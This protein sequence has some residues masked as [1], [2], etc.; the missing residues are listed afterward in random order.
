MIATDPT[1]IKISSVKAVLENTHLGN[2]ER[3]LDKSNNALG[4][5]LL[6]NSEAFREYI[7][8]L[9]ELYNKN[10]YL[11][12]KNRE[13][14]SEKL[15]A[16]LLDYIIQSK[17]NM[18]V[19]ELTKGE[20]SAASLLIKAKSKYLKLAQLEE[21][22]SSY[23]QVFE[24]QIL[25]DLEIIP[26][27]RKGAPETIR[28]STK[29]ES[30]AE[31]NMYTD[32]MRGLRDD[33]NTSELYDA[34]LRIAIVQG[35]YRTSV[36]IKNIIPIEDYARVVTDLVKGIT[37][38]ESFNA[39]KDNLLFQ[40]NNFKDST[41]V[42]RIDLYA[43]IDEYSLRFNSSTGEESY[44]Y[45]LPSIINSQLGRSVIK[46]SKR[47]KGAGAELIVVPRI[48]ESNGDS[49]DFQT[50]QVI[51]P[52]QFAEAA[53][54]DDNPFTYVYGYQLV[55]INGKPLMGV[56][57]KGKPTNEYIYKLVNLYGDGKFT[58]EYPTNGSKSLLENGT[59]K[60]ST[61]F[62]NEEVYAM[63][64]G[65][66]EELPNVQSQSTQP[67]P[68]DPKGLDPF[69]P[70][71]NV[72]PKGEKV[73]EGIYV[74]QEALTKDKQL[75]LFEYLKPF[76]EAQGK[77]TNVSPNA[78]IMIGLGL[79]WDYKKNNSEK[80]S[81]NVGKN[82]AGY[83]TAYAY[84]DLS[85][86]GKPLGKIT[87]RFV[88]LMNKTTGVDISNYDGAIVNIYTN[89][90]FIS[91]HS[92]LE[93]SETAEKY[94]VVVANIGGS[95]NIILGTDANKISKDLKSGAGYLFGYE[96]K[97]RKIPHSTY[98]SDVKGFLPSITVSQEGKTFSEG[99]YRVSITMR[100]VMPLEPG[101]PTS[102]LIKSS[103]QVQSNEVKK[104]VEISSNA[105][106]LAAALTNPTELAKSKGNL[107]ES[108]PVNFN[109]KTYRDAE[110]AYQ[111]LKSTA[112]K[113]E[114]P[115][116][117]YNLMVKI[118]KA[119]LEQ[120]PRLV[121]EIT[122][123]GGSAWI[124]SSTHQPTKQNSVWETGGKNWFIKSLNDA[125]LSI[126]Q[127]NEDNETEQLDNIVA[128]GGKN[129]IV[130][131]S[132]E[133]GNATV[134]FTK[135]DGTKGAE[136]TS[137]KPLFRKVSVATYAQDNPDNVVELTDL[138][139]S[140]KYL[141]IDS[142]KKVVSLNPTSYGDEIVSE[143]VINRVNTLMN[144]FK[145]GININ[146]GGSSKDTT[147]SPKFS[148][149]GKTINTAFDLTKG[150]VTALETLSDFVKNKNGD[151]FITLQGPAGTGKT[152]VIGYLQNYLGSAYTFH[153]MAPT[154]AATA[155]LAFATVKT[156]NKT[157]PA[158]VASSFSKK[159]NGLTK[160][161]IRKLA[162]RNNV[163]VIDEVSMLNSE[164]FN[165]VKNSIDG[166]VIKVIFMGDELQIPEVTDETVTEKQVNKAFS[167]F[168]Q[169]KLTEVKRTSDDNI[170][171][172][173]NT[174]R[175]NIN[176]KIPKIPN[177]NVLKYLKNTQFN[178]KLA[179]S[180][181]TNPEDTMVIAFT[182][183]TVKEHNERI[184]KELGRVG[185][186]QKDDVI[187]GYLGYSSKQI[188]NSDIAN[189][190]QYTVK[191]VKK[192]GSM[193][194]I[195]ATSKKL[196]N[197]R[198]LGVE[199]ISEEFTTGYY[200]LSPN[201]TFVFDDI[202]IVDMEANNAKVSTLM[203]SV[204][205]AKV[206]AQKNFK[207]WYKFYDIVSDVSR[208]MSR[209]DLGDNYIYN[210]ITNRME[211]YEKD[212]HKALKKEYA[213]IYVEK[214]IGL[215]HAVTVH[216]SQGATFK[217]VFFDANSLP[218]GAVSILYNGDRVVGMEKHSLIYVGMSRAS[219]TLTVSDDN[220]ENFYN[221]DGSPLEQEPFDLANTSDTNSIESTENYM[222]LE[223]EIYEYSEINPDM[224]EHLGYSP[225]A[226][227][228][229]MKKV[230]GC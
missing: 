11:S 124:L 12:K 151:K 36:S 200:Q 84:Y 207:D 63:L 184:R 181:E 137:D 132:F 192:N 175:Y 13:L 109:G 19:G 74:N 147:R 29:L 128:Y 179:E 112:T 208:E 162:L 149:K 77:R 153:Y 146:P 97:N 6:F 81:V 134:F 209:I 185:N 190:L 75:E 148:Y 64:S 150:Q 57:S 193:Y 73:K 34:L 229:I 14:I 169:V 225:E 227:G 24:P 5:L 68:S 100:R 56:N 215:G 52:R 32:M 65:K 10:K 33:P 174:I 61:E 205:D 2:L 113:D 183:K 145:G 76:L 70:T 78:P 226:I 71:S 95:G 203:K 177:T 41:I 49:I 3:A 8:E 69:T 152:S 186:L 206:R 58:F 218:E 198:K 108:Y 91:N 216:K 154:H 43:K 138:K 180:I 90:S 117:T 80:T 170:L 176:N 165:L 9:L 212:K 230:N 126:Q 141:F 94:P 123:Q 219:D 31:V 189:S 160:K 27:A 96:G 222:N 30:A 161:L 93:E 116:S 163:I 51:T 221:L 140:P 79:R 59:A 142:T 131:G 1:V 92:D 122:K 214:G 201:D 60:I 47:T 37:L 195:T 172:V 199:N 129:F 85:I 48:I 178:L 197:L 125:Y 191:S 62:T 202:T 25:Q 211:K 135:G 55:K 99:S 120:H 39:F 164:L 224:L 114:G 196:D 136:L 20:K 187:I 98:A 144:Y 102:P 121:S 83:N 44:D 194:N 217:H 7:N 119:K 166:D 111:A 23:Q 21:A 155:E 127:S 110:A 17:K 38:D 89:N 156:G 143:D 42:P 139:G 35:T 86:D 50:G 22:S 220:S 54:Q 28:L 88:E 72:E 115:N 118:I 204:Y 182:N 67:L 106:G 103:T 15:S 53:K 104:G 159:T 210:P 223:G 45:T 40:R 87:P 213:E 26:G 173:L 168:E 130:E 82:L 4:T 228:K 167:E 171:K 158:T 188:E 157:L 18:L 105:K 46:I 66:L 107:T 16:S 101:M 133:S